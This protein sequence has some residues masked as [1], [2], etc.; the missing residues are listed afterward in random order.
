MDFDSQTIV[1]IYKYAAIIFWI[2]IVIA[3]ARFHY[4]WITDFEST[5]EEYILPLG[6]EMLYFSYEA[7]ILIFITWWIFGDEHLNPRPDQNPLLLGYISLPLVIFFD[8]SWYVSI[9]FFGTALYF[10]IMKNKEYGYN[11][12]IPAIIMPLFFFALLK[13]SDIKLEDT[14]LL[15]IVL[16]SV[17]I[18]FIIKRNS[19]NTLN[20]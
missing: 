10:S 2:V 8:V 17:V 16:I 5:R 20:F 19:K 3:T 12:D 4:L 11:F 13:A 1:D 14:T 6:F 7:S 15:L 18:A 9:V